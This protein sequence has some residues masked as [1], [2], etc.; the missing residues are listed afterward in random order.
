MSTTNPSTLEAPRTVF[1]EMGMLTSDLM[2]QF[3]HMDRSE[4]AENTIFTYGDNVGDEQS[5]AYGTTSMDQQGPSSVTQQRE[6]CQV[7]PFDNSLLE[8]I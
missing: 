2:G 4:Q 1:D 6:P 8:V 7:P 3:G 5:V